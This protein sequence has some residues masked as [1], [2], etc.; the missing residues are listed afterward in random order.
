[1]NAHDLTGEFI[2][3]QC[4]FTPLD[5]DRVICLRRYFPDRSAFGAFGQY[6]RPRMRIA[7]NA[8]QMWTIRR[9][10][11]NASITAFVR[12]WIAWQDATAAATSSL[13][14]LTWRCS[15]DCFPDLR[16]AGGKVGFGE[17]FR[18]PAG[19]E[20]SACTKGGR[21]KAPQEGTRG[22][23]C[24]RLRVYGDLTVRWLGWGCAGR[25]SWRRMDDRSARII[26][27]AAV[28]GAILA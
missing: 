7:G 25:R 11:L 21:P 18:M 3:T 15:D 2:L 19:E 27:A 28:G 4:P 8:D 5:L 24:C 13:C 16:R 10:R 12:S 26:V 22:G 20:L 14:R 9:S 6:V 17:G 1:M 23:P